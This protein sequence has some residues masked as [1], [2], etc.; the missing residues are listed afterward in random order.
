MKFCRFTSPAGGAGSLVPRYGILAGEAV[1]EI[2]APPWTRWDTMGRS[3][4]L[5]SVR[6]LAPVE[7]R[8]IVCVGRNYSA[9]AAELG[10][11][12]PKEP[13]IFLKPPTSLIGPSEAIVLNKYSRRVEHEGELGLVIGR[14][15]AHLQDQ[16]DA[17]GYLLGYTCVNDVTARDLQKSDVQFTRAKGFDTFCPTGPHIESDLL[18]DDLLV[19]TLVNGQVR[20]SARTSLMVFR[21]AF[22]VRWISRMMTLEPGDLIATGTP[23]GVG[24]LVSGD[25][26]EVRIG[27]IGVLR[28]PVQPSIA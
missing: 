19:E 4:S 11:D 8:K 17:L 18:P 2:S 3:F 23:A 10:N 26:V 5:A 1:Q 13:L 20:Q 28:N 7:P 12:V 25:T 27:G 22:L 9:H 21:P 6:L 24:P 15:C 16:D 14:R